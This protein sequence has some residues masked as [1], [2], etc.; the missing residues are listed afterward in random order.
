MT[1]FLFVCIENANRSQMAQAFATMH[2][3][4]QVAAYSAGSRPSGLSTPKPLRPWP[5]WAT[6]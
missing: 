6:I 5:S 1:S 2:G 3:G 4:E